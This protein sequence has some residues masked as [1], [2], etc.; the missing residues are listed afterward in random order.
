MDVIHAALRRKCLP[1]PN[2]KGSSRY[3][4]DFEQVFHGFLQLMLL[5]HKIAY[6]QKS[7]KLL[8]GSLNT[9]EVA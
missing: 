6:F 3:G 4:M 8:Y 9:A 5:S 1:N 7:N 2:I